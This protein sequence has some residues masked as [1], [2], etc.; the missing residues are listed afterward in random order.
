MKRLPN[1]GP[2]QGRAP[3]C[4]TLTLSIGDALLR[5]IRNGVRWFWKEW[6]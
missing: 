4:N 3:G 5:A 6:C 1:T 2:L